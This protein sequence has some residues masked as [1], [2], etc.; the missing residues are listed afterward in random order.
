LK[1]PLIAIALLALV[2]GFPVAASAADAGPTA[3]VVNGVTIVSQ[4]D[5]AASLVGVAIVVRAG[6]DRQTMKQSGLAALTAETIVRTPVGTVAKMPLEEAVAAHGGS[7][8]FS[9]DP[10]DVR[11][12]VEALSG[13]APAVLDLVGQALAAPSFAPAT[14]RDARMALIRNIASSQQEAL[15]VG[16]D[17]LSRASSTE[18]NAGLPDLGTPASLTEL[19]PSDVS[20]FYG[21]FYRRGGA[22]ISAVGKLDVLPSGALATLA[23]TLPA[24]TTTAIPAHVAE[25]HGTS[26]ELV[27]HR[28]IASP[29]LI[30]Q[31]AAPG[32][33]SKDFGPM[34]VLTAFVQR[35]L[36]DIASV[37]GVVSQTIATRP[38]GAV[39]AYDRTPS[40]LVI[41]VNGGLGNPNRNFAT[42][43]S[44]VNV[45]AATKLVG[46]IDEFK[47]VAAGDFATGATTLE[48]RAWL[49][50][51]FAAGNSSPDFLDRA[52]RA[53][54]ATT[55]DDVERVARTYLGNPTIALVLPREGSL[56]N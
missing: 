44:I 52:L 51:V 9:V 24:G 14:L 28:D 17:M 19:V 20:G 32:V 31:Y 26:R 25:L 8:H 45:L 4:P 23:S 40:R 5:A 50:A 1:S 35:T 3:Q 36:G 30:A 6:L 39:Y 53:I 11:F 41:Y 55:A 48:S 49:A 29:W 43:L 27:A 34:L 21:T 13:D 42:A 46:S 15:Q 47:A 7:I 54:A 10:D 33:E 22:V 12:Y 18:A 2:A 16:L 38:V 37:P 56:Q